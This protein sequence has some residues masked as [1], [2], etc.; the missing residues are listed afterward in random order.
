MQTELLDL[1]FLPNLSDFLPNLSFLT[2]PT[3][4]DGLIGDGPSRVDFSAFTPQLQWKPT[5]SNNSKG[6]TMN[7]V[8]EVAVTLA[9]GDPKED[10]YKTMNNW[11][12]LNTLAI[13]EAGGT[14]ADEL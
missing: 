5:T 6:A 7:W 14:W 1:S 2:P 8:E 11:Y 3:S 10:P 13:S 9:G 12:T 4:K